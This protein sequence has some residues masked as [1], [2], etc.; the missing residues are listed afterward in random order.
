M[1]NLSLLNNTFGLICKVL[2]VQARV[3]TVVAICFNTELISRLH[4]EMRF[5]TLTQLLSHLLEFADV[6]DLL[7]LSSA[8]ETSYTNTVIVCILP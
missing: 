2:W 8:M 6:S 5:D 3:S 7:S 1:L 4:G